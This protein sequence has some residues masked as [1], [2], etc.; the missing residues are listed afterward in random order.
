[1]VSRAGF[2]PK[3]LLIADLYSGPEQLLTLLGPYD[4]DFY[5]R[6]FWYSRASGLQDTS[7]LEDPEEFVRF[8]PLT[9]TISVQQIHPKAMT[10]QSAE[11]DS[12]FPPFPP[13]DNYQFVNK[14]W[15]PRT[16]ETSRP[17]RIDSIVGEIKQEHDHMRQEN[18]S[19]TVALQQSHQENVKLLQTL[20]RKEQYLQAAQRRIKKLEEEI[21]TSRD[22]AGQMQVWEGRLAACEN[23]ISLYHHSFKENVQPTLIS[24][25]G[26]RMDKQ[27]HV[28]HLRRSVPST[29]CKVELPPSQQSPRQA[30]QPAV[31]QKPPLDRRD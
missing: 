17:N 10:S 9:L 11:S 30:Q 31:E 23:K 24:N 18:V 4:D 25:A 6:H 16:L 21:D 20:Q 7:I 29:T 19:L 12:S 15:V 13:P 22:V 1:M 14:Q 5:A 27:G 2:K 3:Q 26:P 8:M 28:P